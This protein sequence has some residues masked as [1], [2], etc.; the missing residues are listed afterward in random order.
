MLA[1][2][3]LGETMLNG[4]LAALD[5]LNPAQVLLALKDWIKKGRGFPYPSEIREMILPEVSGD[6]HAVDVASSI[7]AAI[8]T[9][10]YTNP[11]R[12]REMIGDLGWEVVQRF[13][14]WRNVC[15]NSDHEQLNTMR[16]QLRGLAEV[17][18]KKSQRGELDHRPELPTA[19][20]IA[21]IVSS[22]L[23]QIE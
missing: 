10:G 20:N 19:A 23:K 16:A 22:A 8:S 12:A 3:E 4:Y 7:I 21:S 11:A 2:R 17:V 13:G 1:G 5:D 9:C 6:D 18:Y 14:G 15:E